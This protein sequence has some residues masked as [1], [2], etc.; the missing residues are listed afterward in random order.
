MNQ[1]NTPQPAPENSAQ[2]YPQV[3][4]QGAPQGAPYAAPQQP[5]QPDV[6]APQFYGEGAAQQPASP[7]P[8]LPGGAIAAMVGG[9]ILV[10][11]LF[12]GS[13]FGI[14]SIV[15]AVSSAGEQATAAPKLEDG[16]DGGSTKKNGK[17]KVELGTK[18][19]KGDGTTVTP[20]K[21]FND[22][23]GVQIDGTPQEIAQVIDEL[24]SYHEAQQLINAEKITPVTPQQQALM[25]EVEARI[26]QQ[27]GQGLSEFDQM[28][29]LSI[30]LDACEAAILLKH[31][32]D[33]DEMRSFANTSPLIELALQGVDPSQRNQAIQ[34]MMSFTLAG[35]QHICPADNEQWTRVYNEIG[36]Q[37]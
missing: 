25:A 15:R 19:D 29:V 36:G 9:G 27:T 11:S 18:T 23:G 14:S 6:A 7:K 28:F 37:W 24:R 32:V 12:V 26:I 13:V 33:A 22:F 35:T 30:A 1:P 3:A 4:P 34:N 8:K 17:K 16:G 21:G 31:D 5:Q 20:P 2:Q 10:L